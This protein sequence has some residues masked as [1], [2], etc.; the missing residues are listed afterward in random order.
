M[1]VHLD[2]PFVIRFIDTL[3]ISGGLPIALGVVLLYM[4][5]YCPERFPP[6]L[7]GRRIRWG[8]ILLI[9]LSLAISIWDALS[10]PT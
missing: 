4:N 6:P 8:A 10:K 5:R 2:L 7:R 1:S 9:V 3:L